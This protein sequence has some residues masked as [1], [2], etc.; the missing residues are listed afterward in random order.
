MGHHLVD[1]ETVAGSQSSSSSVALRRLSACCA[2]CSGVSP[3]SK[4]L[5]M[6]RADLPCRSLITTDRRM[7]ASVNSLCRRFFRPIEY[8]STFASAVKPSVTP[9]I[10]WGQKTP[11]NRLLCAKIANHCASAISVVIT[12]RN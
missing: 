1:D 9:G 12:Q 7:P 10:G 4:P 8:P 5:I 2:T 11:R 6:A 3:S